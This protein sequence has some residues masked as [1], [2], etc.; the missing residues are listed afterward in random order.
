VTVFEKTTAPAA[1]ALRHSRFQDGEWLIDRR[2]EQMQ[3]EGVE[4]LVNQ[5]RGRRR[6]APATAGAAGGPEK[7]LA[8]FDAVGAGR[9]RGSA[10][11]TCPCPAAISTSG[12]LR[13]GLP[14]AAVTAESPAT[15]TSRPVASGKHVVIIGGGDTGSDCVGTSTGTSG[16]GHANSS[17]STSQKSVLQQGLAVLADPAADLVSHEEGQSVTGRSAPRRSSAR[18]VRSRR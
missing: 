2:I 8:D 17:S 5:V 10:R 18:A 14:A 7:L 12:A 6:S 4:F 1:S 3:A 16:V 13:D 9:R 15:R 11:A